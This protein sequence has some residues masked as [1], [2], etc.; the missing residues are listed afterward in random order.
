MDT[1]EKKKYTYHNF[2]NR[3][4]VKESYENQRFY[5]ANKYNLVC[6]H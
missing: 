5:R 6:H 3:Q 1:D 2:T 4:N